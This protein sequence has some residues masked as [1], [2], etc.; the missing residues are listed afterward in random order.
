MSSGRTAQKNGEFPEQNG[1]NLQVYFRNQCQSHPNITAN[2]MILGCG[3]NKPFAGASGTL[4]RPPPPVQGGPG[5]R[6]N[7]VRIAWKVEQQ[8]ISRRAEISY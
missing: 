7:M 1:R 4:A 5:E 8:K 6:G 2:E 3:E